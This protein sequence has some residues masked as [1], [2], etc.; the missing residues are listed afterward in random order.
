MAL[1]LLNTRV[2]KVQSNS[3]HHVRSKSSSPG[4]QTEEFPEIYMCCFSVCMR[5]VIVI[6]SRYLPS[7]P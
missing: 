1:F 6:A 7:N 3:S 5:V 2:K 4:N